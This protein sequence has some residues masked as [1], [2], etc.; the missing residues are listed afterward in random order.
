MFRDL[1]IAFLDG[2]IA[3]LVFNL[4]GPTLA[5]YLNSLPSMLSSAI[6]LGVLVLVV[7]LILREA[8]KF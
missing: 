5:T 8:I 2:A 7:D 3:G 6:I 4:I 1:L